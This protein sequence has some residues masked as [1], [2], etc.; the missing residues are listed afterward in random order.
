MPA[1]GGLWRHRDFTR[2]WAGQTVSQ[3]GTQ[4]TYLALPLTAA[5]TLQATP[6][7]M[8]LL[9]A[10]EFAP[11][12]LFG[13]FAGVWVDRLPRRNI[14]IAADLGRAALLALIPLA[15]LGGFLRIELLYAVGFLTGVL[16]VFFDV[17]YQSY[18]PALVDRADL[19]EGNS[20]LEVTR[21]V[22]QVAG[23][24]AA[25]GLVQLVSAPVAIALD[26]ASFVLSALVLGAIRRAEPPPAAS[27][28]RIWAEIGEGLAV[29]LGNRHLRAIAG[30]TA[31]SNLF[32]QIATA[33]YL[34]YLTRDLAVTPA[35]VGVIFAAGGVGALL[36]ALLA[37]RTAAAVGLGPT[38][39][40]TAALFPLGW[41][42]TLVAGGP[43]ALVV[44]V[45]AAAMA[46]VSLAGTVYNVNQLSLRQTITPDRLQ[47]RM[48]A[49]MRFLVW[50]T[51]PIGALIGGF[52]GDL[53]GLRATLL[54]AA[55][56]SA[57]SVLWV[58]LSPV[59][60][61]REQPAPAGAAA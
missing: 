38:I 34:L 52:L 27:R 60:S 47:G 26:A 10:A 32:S 41:L 40:G 36:G 7:Q 28:R 12:L 22:A 43:P 4:V 50:G 23:P 49:S 48:N 16:T 13:L 29:V 20:K 3:F 57:L 11:F 58:L 30:C 2:L 1:F 33:V 39:V 21:S 61:L 45:L 17:A 54:V 5:V 9:G 56:G 42:L 8:G 6:S 55:L 19:V 15:A 31:T 14:L 24:G 18:L 51:I 53:I 46:L 59:R 37:S 35:L 44:A 25:G